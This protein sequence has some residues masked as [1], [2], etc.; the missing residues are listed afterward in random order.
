M[1]FSNNT[2]RQNKIVTCFIEELVPQDHLVRKLEAAIDFS[3]IYPLVRNLYSTNGRPCIDPVVLFKMLIINIVFGLNSM[4]RTCREIEV[5]TMSRFR[6][7]LI[8]RLNNFNPI[9]DP[10]LGLRGSSE[11]LFKFNS[12]SLLFFYHKF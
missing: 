10:I 11:M 1:S 7:T 12:F 3:F 5:G 6:T 2:I 9:L 8:S 4:R